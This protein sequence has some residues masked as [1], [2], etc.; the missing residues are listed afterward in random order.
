MVRRRN[1]PQ[2]PGSPIYGDPH[3]NCFPSH[4]PKSSHP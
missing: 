3:G 4:T 2:T 1:A